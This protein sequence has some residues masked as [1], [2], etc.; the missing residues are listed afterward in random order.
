MS[1]RHAGERLKLFRERLG[2]TQAELAPHAGT[3]RAG[4]VS[5]WEQSESIDPGVLRLVADLCLNGR[6]VYA[7]LKDGGPMPN[8]LRFVPGARPEEAWEG[9]RRTVAARLRALANELDPP[10]PATLGVD[11]E[12]I[13][14]EE[15]A[16]QSVT[17]PE[18][19]GKRKTGS[20]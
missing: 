13:R 15:A 2:M 17:R 11:V 10:P 5:T 12:R 14:R 19:A 18:Q 20:G 9:E 7:W 16:V 4:T 8:L 6:E 1:E 3:T